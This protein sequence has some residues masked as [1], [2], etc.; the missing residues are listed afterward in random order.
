MQRHIEKNLL[1]SV[2]VGACLYIATILTIFT[3]SGDGRAP[4]ITKLLIAAMLMPMRLF[5]LALQNGPWVLIL[6]AVF[7]TVVVFACFHLWT[8]V[9]LNTKKTN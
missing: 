8:V 6:G 4:A 1:R 3:V 5:G 2:M 7:W 9:S